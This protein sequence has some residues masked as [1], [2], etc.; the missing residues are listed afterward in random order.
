MMDPPV[1]YSLPSFMM[2]VASLPPTLLPS[3]KSILTESLNISLR[4]CAQDVPPIPPPIIAGKNT[5]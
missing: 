4:K 2:V 5:Y 3:Y 1:S